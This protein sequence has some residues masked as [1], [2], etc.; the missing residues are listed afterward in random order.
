M[1]LSINGLS[2]VPPGFRFHPIEEE[3]LHYYLR[4]KISYENI[5]LD[6][7]QEVD[8]N[9]LE[10]WDIH[11][12]CRIGGSEIPHRIPDQSCD[13]FRILESNWPAPHGQKSDWI[14]H[15]YRLDD[16][17]SHDSNASNTIGE[18]VGEDGWVVCRVF[19]KNNYMKTLVSPKT[20]SSTCHDLKKQMV[21]SG[22]DDGV[23]NQIFHYMG[24]TF[25]MENDSLSNNN[26]TLFSKQRRDQQWVT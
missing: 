24:S 6:V 25:K 16:N 7:I 18:S 12:K 5:D 23:L 22:G 4:R 20:L 11:D 14:M 9:K 1:N 10:S 17:T 15:E 2:Q 19:R 26:P 13:G 8:L 3:L 21:C